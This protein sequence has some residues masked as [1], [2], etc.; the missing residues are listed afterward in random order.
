MEVLNQQQHLLP[1]QKP[2]G[3]QAKKQVRFC[4]D[5]EIE[6]LFLLFFFFS[7]SRF[8]GFL[9]F[10]LGLF[11]FFK[12]FGSLLSQLLP[13]TLLSSVSSVSLSS[14]HLS[15]RV[16]SSIQSIYMHLVVALDGPVAFSHPSPS[17]Q[18]GSQEQLQVL[19]SHHLRAQDVPSSSQERN[20]K[21]KSSTFPSE[22]SEK[23]AWILS[24]DRKG[25]RIFRG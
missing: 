5:L 11:Y 8:W 9:V 23:G 3:R 19:P 22:S 18:P 2:T 7:L 4:L 17:N 16:S 6:L 20:W 12:A 24:F 14:N 21:G 10:L 13:C 1:Q 25:Q 15:S